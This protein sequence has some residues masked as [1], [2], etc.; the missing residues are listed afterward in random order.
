MIEDGNRCPVCD[1]ALERL[2]LGGKVVMRCPPCGAMWYG[3]RIFKTCAEAIGAR[4]DPGD[5][6]WQPERIV[7]RYQV[8][9]S[10]TLLCPACGERMDKV[11]FYG[12]EAIV[13]DFCEGC[14]GHWAADKQLREAAKYLR[15]NP[16]PDAPEPEKDAP[17]EETGGLS[18]G[19]RKAAFVVSMLNPFALSLRLPYKTDV[20]V[21]RRPIV[22]LVISVLCIFAFLYMPRDPRETFYFLRFFAITP[23]IV[24]SGNNYHSYLTHM[25]LHGGMLHLLG[26]LYFLAVFGRNV[27]SGLGRRDFT[28]IYFVSGISAAL[29]QVLLS[30]DSGVPMIGASGAISGVLGAYLSLYPDSSVT[31]WLRPKHIRKFSARFYLGAWFGVQGLYYLHQ[32]WTGRSTGVAFAAHLGGF[33]AGWWLAPDPL[34]VQPPAAAQATQRA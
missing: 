9:E 11:P 17:F 12:K 14:D 20:P 10:A 32:A 6:D 15:W 8:L 30:R 34:P 22:M 25:F 18:E 4:G 29:I 31:I 5:S 33:A 21:E 2:G 7:N 19:D 27:E 24:L 23:S 26:N 28:M 16:Q 3:P 1:G 13:V